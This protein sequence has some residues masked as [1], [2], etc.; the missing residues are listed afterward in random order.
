[1]LH[2][3]NNLTRQ[4]EAFKPITEG[5][6]GMYV[7]GI[8]IYDYC[9][10]GHGRTY[11]AFDIIARYFE[12]LGY[13]VTYVR[14]VTD[15]DDKI[16]HRANENEEPFEAVTERY[17]RLM[18][19]DFDAL[20]LRQPDLE[21]HATQSMPEIID[22]IQTLIDKGFAYEGQHGDVYY[23]VS[24][25]DSYGKLSKQHVEDLRSGERVEVAEDKK[26]PLDF[27][28]WKP[29]KPNEP[30]WDSPWGKGRPG[31]HIEC[32]AMSKQCLGDQ[33]D[34]HGGGSDLQFPHHENEIAQS[35]AANGCQFVNYWMHSGMVQV[36]EEKMSKS[37]GNFFTIREVLKVFRAESVRFFLMS[38][39]YRSQLNYTEENLKAADASLE[40]LYLAL[41]D[42]SP[43][44]G[45]LI[46]SYDEK[47]RVAMD[48]DFNTPEA[49]ALLFEVAR[50]LNRAK[51]EQDDSVHDFAATLKILGNA[52]GLLDQSPVEF[53]QSSSSSSSVDVERIESLIEERNQA[54]KDKNFARSDEI[55]DLLLSE[56]IVLEDS[57][58]GTT[59]RQE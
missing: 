6:V 57:R 17:E 39:H 56:G 23:S 38:S 1:M 43:E 31:W 58:D 21:P 8:T 24:K 41:R 44:K 14:N 26:D 42:T 20:G 50:E 29:A 34:I 54:R 3:Y 52:L 7:C 25:F 28:L 27:V 5:K 18:H 36:D 22:I 51:K 2:V 55:R 12:Y 16:I 32:S 49:M 47:F 33:F 40:R 9:H 37:L 53:L 46:A 30:S 10:V 35:E 15:I 59:W 48:D 11:V 13:K 4:K 19:E 45:S